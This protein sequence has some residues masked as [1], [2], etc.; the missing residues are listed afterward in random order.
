MIGPD[1]QQ[2]RLSMTLL[3]SGVRV[4]LKRWQMWLDSYWG[5][6]ALSSVGVATRSMVL[7]FEGHK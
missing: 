3:H 4:L 7:G 2:M 1:D 6:R 5:L